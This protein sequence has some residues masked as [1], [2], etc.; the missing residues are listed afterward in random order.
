[1]ASD[2]TDELYKV[3]LDNGIRKWLEPLKLEYGIKKWR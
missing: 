2:R 3:L 1:M